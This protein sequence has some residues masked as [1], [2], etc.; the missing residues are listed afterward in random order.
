MVTNVNSLTN[1]HLLPFIISVACNNGEFNSTNECFGESWLRA[2]NNEQPTGAIGFFG[3]TISQSWEPPMH[4]QYGMNL[5]L[6]ETYDEH[7]TRTIGGIATN[8]CMYMN[9]MQGSSGINETNYW[10]FFGDPSAILR[11]DQPTILNPNYDDIIIVGQEEFVVDIGING[12]LVALSRGG[13]LIGSAY[14][15]GGIAVID[16]GNNAAYP[17]EIDMVITAFNKFPYESSLT[18]LTPNGAFVTVNNVEVEYGT[19]NIITPGENIDLTVTLENLGNDISSDV[20][21]TLVEMIDNPYI[22]IVNGCYWNY[23]L[24]FPKVALMQM[25]APLELKTKH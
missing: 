7:K 15:S 13:E 23:S 8:G 6:T 20:N 16:L 17:G 22:S 1:E 4:G 9:D 25:Y 19:D 10:T 12:A 2:T 11:T 18:V 14:S 21:V 3:S 24:R 5:I